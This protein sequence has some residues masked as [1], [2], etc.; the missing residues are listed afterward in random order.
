MD[1][2]F[3]KKQEISPISSVPISTVTDRYKFIEQ[4]RRSQQDRII[5]ALEQEIMEHHQREIDQ[6]TNIE[7][8]QLN[9]DDLNIKID[10]V[11]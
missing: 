2:K 9:I 3:S 5:S 8:L 1:A 4:Q 6:N 11:K 10:E 7:L